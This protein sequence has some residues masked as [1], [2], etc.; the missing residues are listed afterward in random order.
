MRFLV[1]DAL[2]CYK[3]S[4]FQCQ[5]VR[6]EVRKEL[7]ARRGSEERD[8]GAII[9]TANVSKVMDCPHILHHAAR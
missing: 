6:S 1:S 9:V 2:K 8:G 3:V 4:H 7:G 5:S